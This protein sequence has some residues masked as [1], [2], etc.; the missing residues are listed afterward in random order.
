MWYGVSLSLKRDEN[1]TICDD[2]DE[3]WEHDAEWSK[4]DRERH[5]HYDLIYMQN[6]LY[7]ESKTNKTTE[8][9]D[10]EDILVVQQVRGWRV[11]TMAEGNQKVQTSRYKL[12]KPWDVTHS[13]GL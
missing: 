10:T 12:R 9:L 6:H 2:V 13:R 8:V 5:I 7:A 11:Y 4:S 1:R 3:S